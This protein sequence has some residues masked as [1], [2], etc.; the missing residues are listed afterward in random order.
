MILDSKVMLALLVQL[1]QKDP[2]DNRAL[3]VPKA[4]LAL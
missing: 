4:L 2:K 3:R 1:D